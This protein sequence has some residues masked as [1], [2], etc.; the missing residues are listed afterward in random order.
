MKRVNIDAKVRTFNMHIIS[1][2]SLFAFGM[3]INRN[4]QFSHFGLLQC[5]LLF[6]YSK[7]HE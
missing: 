4:Q 7:V 3:I 1:I 2:Q 6:E 5:Y